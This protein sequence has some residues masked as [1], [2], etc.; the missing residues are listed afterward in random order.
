MRIQDVLMLGFRPLTERK[1]RAALTILMIVVGIASIIALTSQ[2]AGISN[3]ITASLETLGPTTILVSP[4]F[5]GSASHPLTQADVI[6]IASLPGVSTI[7]PVVEEQVSIEDGGQEVSATVIGASSKGLETLVGTVNLLRGSV[8]PDASVPDAVLGYGIAYPTSGP[9][10]GTTLGQQIVVQ[11]TT[12]SGTKSVTLQV[13][14]VLASSGSTPIIPVDTAIFIPLEAALSLFNSQSY[15]LLLVKAVDTNSVNGVTA[16]LSNIYGNNARITSLQQITQTVSGILSQIGVLF[17]A[18]AG[19]SLTVAGVG[20]TNVML[21]SVYERTREIGILKSLGFRNRGVLLIFLAEAVI[22]GFV[23]GVVGLLVGTGVSYVLPTL[24]LGFRPGS[25]STTTSAGGGG[26][27]G[28]G[29]GGGPNS[30]GGFIS[31][32]TPSITPEIVVISL[33]IAVAV[34]VLAGLYPAWKAAKMPPIKALHYE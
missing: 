26:F 28:G 18:V 24:F 30:G 22:I 27:G 6:Q 8:Y 12:P 7:I 1:T 15:T 23:G 4:N 13:G 9:P 2:T 21:I 14:G 20:I 29:F 31:T 5:G 10:I 19:I 33:V 11:Q 17:G 34:S 25:S 16:L 32:Y 3:S